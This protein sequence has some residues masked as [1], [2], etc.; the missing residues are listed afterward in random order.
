[1][2][3]QKSREQI[4]REIVQDY[5]RR[6]RPLLLSL[7][8]KEEFLDV[9]NLEQSSWTNQGE[10]KPLGIF[11]EEEWLRF[12]AALIDCLKNLEFTGFINR[13]FM[14]KNHFDFEDFYSD[15]YCRLVWK[16]KM[17]TAGNNWFEKAG[18][19]MIGDVQ[20]C[21]IIV[22]FN[23]EEVP[24]KLYDIESKALEKVINTLKS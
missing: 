13:Y 3:Q 16:F 12:K 5:K 18:A 20:D 11:S 23:N 15:F 2:A 9:L 17:G 7:V 6:F 21:W 8:V 4:I 14:T 1:M 24:G 10:N 22:L 19:V